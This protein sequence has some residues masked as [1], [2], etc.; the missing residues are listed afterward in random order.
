MNP[1]DRI[2]LDNVDN[3]I[4][5]KLLTNKLTLSGLH[6]KTKL[7]ITELSLNMRIN[8]LRSYKLVMVKKKDYM[9]KTIYIITSTG[10]KVLSFLK[11]VYDK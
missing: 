1:F 2:S 10:K 5:D 4:L 3:I 9:F 7:S 11:E 6:K 8:K